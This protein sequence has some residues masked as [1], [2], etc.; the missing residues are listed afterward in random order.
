LPSFACYN[1]NR[2]EIAGSLPADEAAWVNRARI[3]KGEI[4]IPTASADPAAMGAAKAL[5]QAAAAAR[6]ADP[7]TASVDVRFIVMSV[8]YG[9]ITEV[10]LRC[11]FHLGGH[12]KT[13]FNM[14]SMSPSML[15]PIDGWT[16][17]WEP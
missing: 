2:S 4:F 17:R 9:V 14:R 11:D 8:E 16:T 1:F 3:S 10:V 5:L 7:A 13:D 12:I 15:T 6:W